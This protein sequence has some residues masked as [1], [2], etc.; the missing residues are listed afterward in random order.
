MGPWG[1]AP[2]KSN[3]YH[4]HMFSLKL[5]EPPQ[6]ILLSDKEVKVNKIERRKAMP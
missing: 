4:V 5:F 6:K 3:S 2:R 1:K